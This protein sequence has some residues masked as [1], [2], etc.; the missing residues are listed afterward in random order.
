LQKIG[1]TFGFVPSLFSFYGF[2]CL[3]GTAGGTCLTR[4]TGIA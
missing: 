2:L 1:V 3:D 4:G